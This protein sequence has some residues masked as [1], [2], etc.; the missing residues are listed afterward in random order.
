MKGR[1]YAKRAANSFLA[2]ETFGRLIQ[3]NNVGM[4]ENQLEEFVSELT[5]KAPMLISAY[6]NGFRHGFNCSANK[7]HLSPA[8]KLVLIRNLVSTYQKRVLPEGEIR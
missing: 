5:P 2:G 1:D 4:S 6:K 8:E 3:Q 7:V